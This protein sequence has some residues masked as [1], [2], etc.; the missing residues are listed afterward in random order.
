VSRR[1][2]LNLFRPLTEQYR[3]EDRLGL[4]NLN[5][6]GS[7]ANLI[8]SLLLALALAASGFLHVL[9]AERSAVAK[10]AAANETPIHAASSSPATE[11]YVFYVVAS[12]AEREEFVG[13]H[14]AGNQG[15]VQIAP[16]RVLVA[17]S[18]EERLMS[19]EG[20]RELAAHGVHFQVV[21]VAPSLARSEP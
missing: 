5:S 9:H 11:L 8:A 12:E 1:L 2:N 3:P 21:E 16:G 15:S 19:T 10:P 13:S 6:L 14:V 18:T 20:A 4:M 17:G 7:V